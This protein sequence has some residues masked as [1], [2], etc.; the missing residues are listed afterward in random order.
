MCIPNDCIRGKA[1]V[2]KGMVTALAA[3]G[4]SENFLAPLS[5]E[6]SPAL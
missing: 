6:R 1:M 2:N 3:L 5:V 4:I